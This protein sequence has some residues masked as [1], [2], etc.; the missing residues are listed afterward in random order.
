MGQIERWTVCT[1]AV[2][3]ARRPVEQKD[4]T[5]ALAE[6]TARAYAENQRARIAR[7]G[8][9]HRVTVDPVLVQA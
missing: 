1:W 8:W 2:P 9:T 7:N 5:G 3:D 4:F 6:I